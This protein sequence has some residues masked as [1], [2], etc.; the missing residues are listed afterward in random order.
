MIRFIEVFFNC[1]ELI[2]D[3]SISD[4]KI[5]SWRLLGAISFFFHAAV[6]KIS[7]LIVTWYE[8]SD[9]GH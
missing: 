3:G 1:N 8:T 2:S 6:I 4:G 5:T 7:P 9:Y